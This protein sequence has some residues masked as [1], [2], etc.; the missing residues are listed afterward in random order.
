[1]DDILDE[2]IEE[3][4][5]SDRDIFTNIWT[6]PR[7]VLKYINDNRYDKYVTILLLLEGMSRAFDRALSKHLGQHMSL[8]TIILI[9]VFIGGLFGWISCYIY[10][11]LLSWTGKWLNG[12][13]TRSS[14]LTVL[15]YATVPSIV[16]LI[17]LI[18][19]III[20]GNEIFVSYGDLTSK[21][22]LSNIIGYGSMG[23]KLILGILTI[24]FCIVG[25]SEVQK[26][27]IGK[28]IL[29]LLLAVLV[30]FVPIC[31]I[32]VLLNLF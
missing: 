20:Y 25:V 26:F 9:C 13:G 24:I 18:P 31:I 4:N 32:V 10:A 2:R 11:S 23:I 1:M 15:S 3:E 5:L 30:I 6:S 8:W 7:Q 16:G 28:S 17:F 21:D 29:N 19:Q 12:Q 22:L 27:S 14:L